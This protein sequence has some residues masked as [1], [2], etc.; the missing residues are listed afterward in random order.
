M[1]ELADIVKTINRT[2]FT[3]RFL[4]SGYGLPR[5]EVI[6]NYIRVS[7]D[8][9]TLNFFDDYSIGYH[10]FN[11]MLLVFMRCSN[12]VLTTPFIKF[13]EEVRLRFYLNISTDFLI[14]TMVDNVGVAQI[15][16]FSN[17]INIGTGGFLSMH[18]AGVDKDDLE[19]VELA[20]PGEACFG[21]IDIYKTGAINDAYTLFLGA[22]ETLNSPGY[23]IR[24]ISKI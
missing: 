23:S 13:S 3:V 1:A 8:E 6:S 12:G 11:D 18:T 4:H 9:N 22:E 24:F 21:V 16:Q 15:Y 2:L 14:K 10:F 17:K 19:L 5:P 7:P 20:E